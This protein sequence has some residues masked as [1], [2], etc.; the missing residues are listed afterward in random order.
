VSAGLS[1]RLMRRQTRFGP[2][3]PAEPDRRSHAG[4]QGAS[5]LRGCSEARQTRFGA[6]GRDR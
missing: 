6:L 2:G 5:R 4:L 1:W 3:A